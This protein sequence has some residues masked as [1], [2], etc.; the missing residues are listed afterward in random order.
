M[1]ARQSTYAELVDVLDLLPRLLREIRRLRGLS[2]R[3]AADE[4]GVAFNSLSRFERGQDVLLSNAV[5]VL[6]WLDQPPV[7]AALPEVRD[8]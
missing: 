7:S 8:A 4:I 3:A 2:L 5:A 1:S 6:K